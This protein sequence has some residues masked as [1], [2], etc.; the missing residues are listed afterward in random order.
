[1]FSNVNTDAE[2]EADIRLFEEMFAAKAR[3]F[4]QIVVNRVSEGSLEIRDLRQEN[5]YEIAEFFYLLKVFGIDSPAKL[6]KFAE[7]HTRNIE[8]LLGDKAQMAKLGVLPQRLRGARFETVEKLDRLVANCGNG[9]IHLSQSDLARF[10]VE[11]MSFESCRTS[12]KI[13]SRVG[14]FKLSKSPFGAILVTSTGMLEDIYG[15]YIRSFRQG[16][17]QMSNSCRPS[18]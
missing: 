7:S 14:Y 13:L 16:I 5:V 3:F 18:W 6:R 4:D 17:M 1:M 11:Y 9:A 2:L 8:E 10:L 12:V 15:A